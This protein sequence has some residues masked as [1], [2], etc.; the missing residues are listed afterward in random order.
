MAYTANKFRVENTKPMPLFAIGIFVKN[1]AIGNCYFDGVVTH[2]K[3]DHNE[4]WYIVENSWY[5]EST[6]AIL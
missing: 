6:I 2:M 3:F 1:I 4:W 5:A